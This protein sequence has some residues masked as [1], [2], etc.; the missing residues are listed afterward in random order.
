[1]KMI[2][3]DMYP[4]EY[5]DPRDVSKGKNRGNQIDGAEVLKDGARR[6]KPSD[7]YADRRRKRNWGRVF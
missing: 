6:F 5:V 3:F 7:N 2:P 4:G 1:M